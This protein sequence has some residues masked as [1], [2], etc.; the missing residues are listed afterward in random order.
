MLDP[1]LLRNDLQ[2]CAEKLARR[3]YQ[4]EVEILQLL[5]EKRKQ[6]QVTTEEL[7]AERKQQLIHSLTT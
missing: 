1:K 4:L 3:G 2:T 5:E 7:Q 6:L